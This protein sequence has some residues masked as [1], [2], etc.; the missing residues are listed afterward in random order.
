M[1]QPTPELPPGRLSQGALAPYLRAIRTHKLIVLLVTLAAVTGALAWTQLR[2]PVYEA[3]AEIL[4]NPLPQG[5]TTFLGL[6]LLTDTGDPVRTVQTAATVLKSRAAADRVAEELGLGWS[7][8]RVLAN[9]DVEAMGESNVLGVTARAGDP[10]QA[11]RIANEFANAAV[12]ARADLLDAQIDRVIAPIRERL[13]AI[14]SGPAGPTASD[15]GARL[16]SLQALR[17]G[18]DPTVA[19]SQP[20][21]APEAPVGAGAPV[22]IVLSL[23]AGI[24]L[25]SAVAVLLELLRRTLRDEQEAMLIWPI[26]VLARVPYLGRRS[27]WGAGGGGWFMPPSVGEAFRSLFVQLD[28]PRD[29]DTRVVM[30]T[31]ASAGDGKTTSAINLAMTLAAGDNQVTLMDFDVRR[32]GVAR[33][34]DLEQDRSLLAILDDSTTLGEKLLPVPGVPDLS[35]LATR[36][37]IGNDPFIVET[38]S[39]RL[40]QLL[41]AARAQADFI[42][43]DTAPLGEISDALRLINDIDDLLV[44]VRPEYTN[45]RSFELMR[46]LLERS[47]VRPRGIIIVGDNQPLTS[48]YYEYGGAAPEPRPRPAARRAGRS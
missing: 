39:R 48:G 31:S 36:A 41:K 19:L 27:R 38:V 43:V 2:S 9:V 23:L 16:N 44:V 34:L 45:R 35:V 29:C 37:P 28:G 40:P 6:Q 11:A 10:T 30:I 21:G 17:G 20:A 3:T 42:V 8:D 1:Y 14:G 25:G 18:N 26:P 33:A 4:I 15:L 47:G 32:P 7:P 22:V 13:D 12:A 5:E 24:G 46:D